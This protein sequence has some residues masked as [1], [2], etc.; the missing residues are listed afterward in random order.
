MKTVSPALQAHFGGDVTTL[1]ILWKLIRQD[2]VTSGFTTHDVDIV[3]GGVT[4]LA[5]TG[6]T[7]TASSSKSDLSVDNQEVTAFLDSN[8]ISEADIRAG[9]YDYAT[10]EIIIV[11]WADL[12]MGDFKIRCG[13]VGEIKMRNGVFTAEIRG[14]TQRL[15][16]V[17]GS[18]YGPLCRAEL[19]S[20]T[21]S[22]D[23]ENHYKCK[24]DI[25]TYR[26]SGTVTSSAD[27]VTVVPGAGLLMVGSGTPAT[28]APAGWFNDGL[29]TFTS[30]PMNNFKVE[31]KTWDGTT[32][33]MFL[34]MAYQPVAGNTFT[35][36][37]GCN[38]TTGD[39]FGKFN[40]IINFRG[41][42]FIPGNDLV[43]LY[44]NQH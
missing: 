17:I 18:L 22:I 33:K 19:G 1:A 6:M 24:V 31:V 27:A 2:A 34:P 12:T 30:G 43:T 26:Q 20:G 36:E 14:L 28:A 11:N 5:D 4:Y 44:P 42:P 21:N 38:K 15:T 23:M 25:S 8:T 39:C 3:Y 35:I 16:T 10:V 7:N 9:L 40:N 37:P 29:L 13:S 32:L 41:E